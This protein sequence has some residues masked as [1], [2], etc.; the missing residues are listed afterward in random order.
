M[1]WSL[2]VQPIS[3]RIAQSR[4]KV[5]IPLRTTWIYQIICLQCL[6]ITHSWYFDYRMNKPLACVCC[7]ICVSCSSRCTTRAKD[8]GLSYL[9]YPQINEDGKPDPMVQK[10]GTSFTDNCSMSLELVPKFLFTTLPAHKYVS[11]HAL[12]HNYICWE[13]V[14]RGKHVNRSTTRNGTQWCNRPKPFLATM[15]E[16]ER[17]SNLPSK[18]NMPNLPLISSSA[19]A[20]TVYESCLVNLYRNGVFRGKWKSVPLGWSWCYQ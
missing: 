8:H 6:I 20:A 9:Y 1:W 10:V 2:P 18:E 7:A 3:I 13:W 14:T 4:K 5:H 15:H 11:F 17:R 12:A 19:H 16:A